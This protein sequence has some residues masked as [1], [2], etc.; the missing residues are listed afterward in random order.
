MKT[1]RGLIFPALWTTAACAP[2]L[3]LLADFGTDIGFDIRFLSRIFFSALAQS[4][5]S[6]LA[7]FAVAIVPAYYCMGDTRLAKLLRITWVIPFFYPVISAVIAFTLIYGALPSFPRYSLISVVIAH[8]FFNSPVLVRYLSEAFSAFPRSLRDEAAM[9]GAGTFA[10]IVYL[11]LPLALK[12]LLRGV[13]LTFI[14]CFTSFGV[15]LSFGTLKTSTPEVEIY[16]ALQARSD[17]PGALAIALIQFALIALFNWAVSALPSYERE[18][19]VR[20]P[21]RRNVIFA[22]VSGLWLIFE[23]LIVILP[24]LYAVYYALSRKPQSLLYIFSMPFNLRFPVLRS[25]LNSC[26]ISL[27]CAAVLTILAWL[28][29]S[30]KRKLDEILVNSLFGLSPALLALSLLYLSI[31]TGINPVLS[32]AWGYLV[33]ALPYAFSFFQHHSAR[34]DHTLREQASTDGAGS[35]RIF[36]HIEW[37]LLSPALRSSFIQLFAI[38]FGEFTISYIFQL[39][40]MFPLASVTAYKLAARRMMVESYLF[41]SLITLLIIVICAIFV[42]TP[43]QTKNRMTN[44]E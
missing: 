9:S 26:T 19:E 7:C 27:V 8:I 5:L 4:A 20:Q 39:P 25:L 31:R 28:L 41:T 37:P 30:R 22:F 17:F 6:T 18:S 40:D 32:L 21:L 29:V 43:S 23:T 36:Y 35:V 15:V 44:N 11:Q 12:P 38:I 33:L 3:L 2:F 42:L 10:R 13:F 24:L 14:F 16:H 1:F 34:F